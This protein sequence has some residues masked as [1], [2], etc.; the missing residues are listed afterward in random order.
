ML[1]VSQGSTAGSLSIAND[2][3]F[4]F[5][6]DD[7]LEG[8][9]IAKTIYNSGIKG[10]V[11]LGRDDAGNNGLQNSV[12]SV[13]TLLGGHVAS[14]PS[15]PVTTTDFTAALATIKTQMQAFIAQYGASGTGVYLASFDE[16]AT[17][18]QQAAA[19]PFFSSVHWYGGDGVVS[20]AAFT[21]NAAAADFAI[22]TNFFAPTYGLPQQA[23]SKWQPV[24]LEIKSRTG[25]DA[26]AFALAS[27]D[28]LW[29]LARTYAALPADEPT[30]S[31]LKSNFKEQADMFY[32]LTGATLLNAAGDRAIGSFDYWGLEN[33][34][35]S[36]RWV[37]KGRSE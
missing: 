22:A 27:Y 19:D 31:D 6:P 13:Y 7:R 15:Y 23:A 34:N 26:D 1:V 11:I 20:S 3:L 5:C 33:Q 32:G 37:L 18:F 35:G 28:A 17:L 29:V 9:A 4:R 21:S 16:G 8:A 25:L 24:A 36:Y 30:F 14:N 12:D 2:N 10:L